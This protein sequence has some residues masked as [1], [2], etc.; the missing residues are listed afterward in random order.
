LALESIDSAEKWKLVHVEQNGLQ[1]MI[2]TT[3]PFHL[4]DR[5]VIARG[6]STG[7]GKRIGL[8]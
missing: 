5:K 3:H 2:I 7:G 1:N 8:S 4:L 6:I